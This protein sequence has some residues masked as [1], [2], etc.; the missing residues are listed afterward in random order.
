MSNYVFHAALILLLFMMGVG[1]G[2]DKSSMAAMKHM[3]LR[4]FVVPIATACGSVLGGL[5]SGLILNTN[6]SATAAVSAGYGWYTLAGPLVGQL[7]GFEWGALGFAVNLSRELL[8]IVS[9]PVMVKIDK[10]A[11]IAFG[12][13]TTMDTTFPI[14]VR[15]CGSE[16]LVIS[17]SSGLIL[18]AIAP[19][20]IMAIASIT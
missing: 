20:S 6:L 3:G 14:I 2:L 5:I 16:L 7:Y 8:T 15:Y 11:P 19:F 12:G 13:A 10:Y 17:F 9:I 4:V 18:S 1:F